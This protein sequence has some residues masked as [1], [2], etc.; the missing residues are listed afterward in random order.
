VTGVTRGVCTDAAV[1]IAG[2]DPAIHRLEKFFRWVQ[3]AAE[4]ELEKHA[5]LDP[6]RA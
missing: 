5:C 3:P 1:V 2:L 4:R 6:S